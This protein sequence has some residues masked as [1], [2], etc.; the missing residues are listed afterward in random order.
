[1]PL[2]PVN[3]KVALGIPHLLPRLPSMIP[4]GWADDIHRIPLLAAYQDVCVDIP[5]IDFMYMGKE[6]ACCE[7]GMDIR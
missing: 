3:R 5:R 6:F 2:V 7:S 1:M 4:T